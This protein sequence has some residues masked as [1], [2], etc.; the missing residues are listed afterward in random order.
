ME[1][2]V[3]TAPGYYA[4]GPGAMTQTPCAAGQY[5]PDSGEES[6]IPA[7][8][9]HYAAGP[10]AIAQTA[11]LAGSYASSPGQATCTNADP[12]YV[13]PDSAGTAE[14]PCLPGS[15]QP[16]SGEVLCDQ[17]MQGYEVPGSHATSQT[18]CPGGQFQDTTGETLCKQAQAGHFAA[19][20][21][22]VAQT[23]CAAGS[24]AASSG[25][26]ACTPASLGHDVSGIGAASQAACTEGTFASTTG[27]SMCTQASAG[28]DVALAG[29]TTQTPCVAQTFSPSAG[30]SSCTRCPV[31]AFSPEGSAG[32]TPMP[33]IVGAGKSGRKLTC[34]PSSSSFPSSTGYQW[35]RDGTPIQG[36]SGPTYA[37]QT[38]DEGTGLTCAV[39]ASSAL[40]NAT[41]TSK[42][43]QIQ[44]P[45]VRGCPAATGSLSGT[46]LGLITLGATRAQARH[47]YTHSSTRG[48]A[49]KD[50]FCLTPFGVRVGYASPTLL[51]HL[52]AAKRR[53]LA[54]RVVWASTDNARYSVNGIRAGA[55]LVSARQALPHGDY[56]R[57]GLNYWYLAPIKGATAVLKVRHGIVEEV[58]IADKQLTGS[59]RANRILMSSFD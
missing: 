3:T 27:Q 51:K 14:T 33:E 56:F 5:Q 15:Y 30:E 31:G 23:E 9:G 52:G 21:A 47:R 12:G 40:G 10:A 50:F 53:K 44:V 11:C 8:I 18:P 54:G 36:A 45:H 35:Y 19:G 7:Q 24:Y 57:L 49:Y 16:N 42:P 13:V 38:L 20:P 34:T 55:T 32:C 46:T 41:A 25:E 28:Y 22:A 1:P 39:T 58:G 4:V 26:S 59:H 29:G 2:C 43:L 37:V 17:P 6:C 48:F